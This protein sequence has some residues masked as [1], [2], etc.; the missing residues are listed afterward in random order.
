MRVSYLE[1][2]E[3]VFKEGTA[4]EGRLDE[5]VLLELNQRALSSQ[6]P[7]LNKYKGMVCGQRALC[8][9]IPSL[10]KYKGMVC[11]Q[12]ALQRPNPTSG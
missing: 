9:Q 6:I 7:R 5:A 8:S 2:G 11:G 3:L 10:N 12:R 4:R 1:G